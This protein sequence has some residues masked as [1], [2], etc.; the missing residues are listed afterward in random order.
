MLQGSLFFTRVHVNRWWTLTQEVLV[1][2]H[3]TMVALM[4]NQAGWTMFLFGFTAIFIV[5]QMHGLAWSR[6]T[7]LA[8]AL[9]WLAAAA[10]IYSQVGWGRWPEIYRIPMIDYLGVLVL[11]LLFALLVR[12]FRFVPR[13]T[14]R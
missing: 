6:R 11:G 10:A 1:V 12:V 3:G 5:T 4:Q 2:V 7:R 14:T 13:H 8:V 9:V